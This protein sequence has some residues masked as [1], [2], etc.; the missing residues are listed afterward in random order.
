M[1]AYQYAKD[2]FLATLTR[3]EMLPALSGG[4][5]LALSGGKDSVLLLSL[6]AAYA[7]EN[8]IPL[9]AMHLHHGIRGE[10]ADRDAA[11]CRALCER[12]D[13][14]FLLCH[15]DVPALAAA[16]G[17]GIEETARH[18]RYRLLAFAARERGYTAILTAH[19][20]TDNAETVLFQILRG[21]GT[22][23]L[24]GI[25]PKRREGEDLTVLRPLIS[26]STEDVLAALAEAELPYV[27]DST[28]ADTLYTRNFL[29]REVLP[30]LS[31]VTPSPARAFSRMTQNVREDAAL[32]DAMAQEQFD[33]L[34]ADG[35]LDAKGFFSLPDALRF[36]VLRMLYE[37]EKPGEPLPSRTHVRAV[38]VLADKPHGSVS[39]PGGLTVA[40]SGD[41]LG[42][43][44]EQ[45]FEHP[46]TPI[47]PG[48]NRLADGS[49]LWLLDESSTPLP[50]IVY[51]LSTQRPLA[52]ATIEGELTVRSRRE[53]DAYRFGGM[54]HKVKKLFSDRKIPSS[55]RARVPVLCDAK[56]ILW[57][58]PFG[59]REDGGQGKRTLTLVYLAAK[60]IDADI[61]EM[62]FDL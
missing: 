21:G 42:F 52:F 6:F 46:N 40:R 36:R 54:T 2:A 27:T 58:P 53:G 44:E 39:M 20:A 25:P 56:G 14:P 22:R 28:N 45:P 24:C 51:T 9:S 18:E 50:A 43:G 30:L 41:C 17:E 15:A 47:H 57:V 7:K 62:L 55:L 60:D 8:G 33:T 48:C 38:S 19:T 5:L 61:T 49:L 16:R 1:S 32:L 3:E 23:A 12:L 13:V 4:A 59:V 31:R 34:Y 10:E 11:F 29:R 35:G 26:L 37:V